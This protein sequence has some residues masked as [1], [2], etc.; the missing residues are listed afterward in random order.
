MKLSRSIALALGSLSLAALAGGCSGGSPSGRGAGSSGAANVSGSGSDAGQGG[1]TSNPG[2]GGSSTGQGGG[3]VITQGGSSGGGGDTGIGGAN[4][5]KTSTS[6]K[7]IPLDLYV[8]MDSSKSMLELTSSGTTKWKAVTDAM[9]AF[10]NDPNTTDVNVALKY[11]P[12]EQPTIPASCNADADCAGGTC[13]QR[14]ACVTK[15]TISKAV[16]KLCA[17]DTEC[18]PTEVCA[19][20]QR[21]ADGENCAKQYCMSGGAGAPC[22]ADC[23]P[24][25]GYCNNRD[26]C[27]AANYAMPAVPFT[28]LPAGGAMLAQSFAT[29][30]PDGFTPTGPSLAGALQAAQ[31]RATEYPDHKVVLV[32]VT[33]GLP[34]GYIPGSPPPGC[35]PADIPGISGV[36]AS[37]L[38]GAEGPSIPTFVIGV[39]GP[40]DLIDKNTMP[41]QNLDAL[42]MSGGTT[43]SVVIRTDE[44]VAQRLQ[45]ALKIVRTSAIACQYTIPTPEE[46]E[47]DYNFVNLNFTSA[48]TGMKTIGY[49]GSKDKCDPELGGWY[50]DSNPDD[51]SAPRP[52]QIIVCDKS[53]ASFQEQAD[54]RVDIALGCRTMPVR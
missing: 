14:K 54:A 33:D 4:C 25:T 29:R 48:A 20:V 43:K 18:D 50:Y 41:Q 38:M 7:L 13:D 2:Q 27:T 19:P 42:A 35:V 46:G 34:G 6:A 44:N 1:N 32:L 52:K 28:A 45:D 39:F 22:P 53:C 12:D 47:L 40:C 17:A 36:L 16:T 5:A 23:M 21:C 24:F 37:G 49:A 9:T 30:T 15:D 3:L 8:L 31:Q 11:F 51:A 10:F 26:I